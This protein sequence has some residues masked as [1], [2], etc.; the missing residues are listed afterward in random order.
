MLFFKTAKSLCLSLVCLTFISPVFAQK[1]DTEDIFAAPYVE[2]IKRTGKLDFK[3][4]LSLSFKSNGYLDTLSVDQGDVFKKGQVLAAL[5]IDEL[6]ALKNASYAQLLQAKREVNRIQQLIDNNL[7]SE[8]ELDKA[9]TALETIRASYK[10]DFYNLEKAQIIAPFDGVVLSRTT[11]LGAF[12]TPGVEALKVAALQNNWVIKVALT[13]TE[14]SQVRIGQK[15][16]VNLQN[17]GAVN[18]EVNR[19]PAIANSNNLFVIDVLLPKLNLQHG[20]IAG[21]LAEVVIDYTRD[22]LVYRI[23]ISALMSVNEQGQA[24]VLLASENGEK[25]EQQA[26]DIFKINNNSVYLLTD[27]PEKMLRIVTQGWQH[28]SLDKK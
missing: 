17:I 7:S 8:Q 15:V 16:R 3:R 26:F 12:N 20:I 5:E 9:E 21:Q 18:G 28:I 2:A 27:T 13:G 22:N 24:L 6:I 11:E 23:P 1:F 14:I 4:T 10:V 25:A 19:I